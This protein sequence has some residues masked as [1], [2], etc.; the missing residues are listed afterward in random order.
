MLSFLTTADI[1]LSVTGSYFGAS[2]KNEYHVNDLTALKGDGN[3][4]PD[5]P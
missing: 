3:G 4:S 2:P 5:Y 1:P